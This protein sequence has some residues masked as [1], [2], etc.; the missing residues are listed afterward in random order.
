M[1]TFQHQRILPIVISAIALNLFAGSCFSAQAQSLNPPKLNN[2]SNFNL[3]GL[4]QSDVRLL[5]ELDCSNSHN[6]QISHYSSINELNS[7]LT[8]LS[9]LYGLELT[10]QQKRNAYTQAM[11][12][13][14]KSDLGSNASPD[15]CTTY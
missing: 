14:S 13:A 3:D 10:D 6:Q 8:H 15:L 2:L 12:L 5:Q 11:Q 4:N 7:L 9:S 1:K